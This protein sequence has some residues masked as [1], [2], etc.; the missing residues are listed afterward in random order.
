MNLQ[1]FGRVADALRATRT[2]P[3]SAAPEQASNFQ[4]PDPPA[5]PMR[6]KAGAAGGAPSSRAA[7][8][9]RAP[10]REGQTE[11]VAASESEAAEPARER[12]GDRQAGDARRGDARDASVRSRERP[13]ARLHAEGE[14]PEQAD[15]AEGRPVP[16]QS[17]SKADADAESSVPMLHSDAPPGPPATDAELPSRMLALLG[18]SAGAATA[19]TPGPDAATAGVDPPQ[20]DAGLTQSNAALAF[21]APPGGAPMRASAGSIEAAPVAV[22]GPADQG[23][24]SP[25]AAPAP[26]I[27]PSPLAGA[28]QSAPA[29]ALNPRVGAAFAAAEGASVAAS[30]PL[31]GPTAGGGATP[32]AF[33]DALEALSSPVE[34]TPVPGTAPRPGGDALPTRIQFAAPVNLPAQPGLALDD[35]FDQRIVWMAEQRIGQAEMRVSPDGM[36]AIDVRLQVEGQRVTAQ[37]GAAQAE[38]RQAL[39]AGM[40]RLRDLLEQRGMQLADAQVGQ[41]GSQH[42]RGPAPGAERGAQQADEAPAVTTI[43]ALR[44]RGLVDEYV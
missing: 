33:A 16:R 9:E 35:G 26:A 29:A 43:R 2:G 13:A 3:G 44:A 15:T 17:P 8:H 37:F 10:G 23:V 31:P 42:G 18:A 36:G 12:E 30:T 14:P 20:P 24:A 4:L 41:Q 28:G 21:A 22:P 32:G 11:P 40:D 1:G 5:D 38:V 6:S 27:S 7:R 34:P 39:E 19:S 25:Q